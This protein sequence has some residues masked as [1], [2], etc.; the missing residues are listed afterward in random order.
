MDAQ[1]RRIMLQKA[2][3]EGVEAEA[4]EIN[5]L[6][7][8]IRAGVLVFMA[9]DPEKD[10]QRLVDLVCT[11]QEQATTVLAWAETKQE[12]LEGH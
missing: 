3:E 6:V 11:L 9:L 10:R 12:E 2:R 1:L 7:H 5:D 4:S 8:E